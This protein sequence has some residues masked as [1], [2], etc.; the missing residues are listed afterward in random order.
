[1]GTA[2]EQVF[3]QGGER[4]NFE[5]ERGGGIR[6]APAEEE[7]PA[8][9]NALLQQAENG[10]LRAIKLYYELLEKKRRGAGGDAEAVEDMAEIRRAVFGDGEED[11]EG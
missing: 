6:D 11:E 9:W 1:M 7:N 10:D 4:V 8:I 2:K 3:E 5:E